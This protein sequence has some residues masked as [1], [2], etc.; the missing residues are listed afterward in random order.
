MSA[1]LGTRTHSPRY[2]L[3]ILY[4]PSQY[5]AVA[6]MFRAHPRDRAGRQA[7]QARP[8]AAEHPGRIISG[9]AV[10]LALCGSV[11]CPCLYRRGSST[12]SAV[13]RYLLLAL[14]A[15]A[16]AYLGA[17]ALT[18]YPAA[19]CS[20]LERRNAALPSVATHRLW[21]EHSDMRGH[22]RSSPA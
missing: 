9:I 6:L 16:L 2:V 13:R 21:R 8:D 20:G 11:L 19:R 4:L 3:V 22:T 15:A 12:A 17:K 10:A 1:I 7:G 14:P 18:G 5:L